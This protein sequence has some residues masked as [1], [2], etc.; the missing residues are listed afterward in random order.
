MIDVAKYVGI[1]YRPG[2]KGPAGCDC[3][4]L[5]RWFYSDMGYRLPVFGVGEYRTK[6][7]ISKIIS[8]LLE[9]EKFIS[10]DTPPYIAVL[11]KNGVDADH[12][13]IVFQIGRILHANKGT[14]SQNNI[15]LDWESQIIGRYRWSKQ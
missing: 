5:V 10:S 1:R 7:G 15:L 2:G 13:G 14:C 3:W 8:E 12:V 9:V 6:E 4:G 11:A